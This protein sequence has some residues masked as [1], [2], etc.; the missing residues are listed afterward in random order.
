M[1]PTGSGPVPPGLHAALVRN[2]GYL[3]SRCGAYATRQFSDRMETIGLN[4]RMWGALNVLAAEG[5]V[6]QQQL[7]QAIG[8]DPSSMVGTID[9]L[10]S[11]GLVQRRPHPSDRRAHALHLTDAG[12]DILT[13]GR[14][15]A[16]AA[17]E[18]LLAPL[19]ADDRQRLHD[20]LLRIAEATHD[21]ARR[22]DGRT[23]GP[24]ASSPGAP[25]D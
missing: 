7:G 17:Q 25:A 11:R 4:A 12:R 22:A 20:L 2:T 24:P 16:R 6:S 15:V 9:E 3:I 10:E 21:T 13:S 23:G 1:A 18:E 5:P 14:G 8:M 19:D